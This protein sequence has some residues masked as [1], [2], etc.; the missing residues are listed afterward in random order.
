MRLLSVTFLPPVPGLMT[1]IDFYTFTMYVYIT[2]L[3]II[4]IN[5]NRYR[6]SDHFCSA[7]IW[8]F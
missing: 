6:F 3:Y 4:I 8:Q 1:S 5:F 7:E 2:E